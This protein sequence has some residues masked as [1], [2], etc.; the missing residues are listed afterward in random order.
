MNHGSATEQTR[1]NKFDLPDALLSFKD[2]LASFNPSKFHSSYPPLHRMRQ[3]R[4]VLACQRPLL[5]CLVRPCLSRDGIHY[6]NIREIDRRPLVLASHL[7]LARRYA[8]P[9]SATT[10]VASLIEPNGFVN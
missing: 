9:T 2:P 10:A 7:R 5:P 3:S 1:T 6:E 8:V 4:P